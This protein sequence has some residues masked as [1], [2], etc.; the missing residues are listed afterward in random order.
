MEFSNG[1]AGRGH[2]VMVVS[3]N[4]GTPYP[5]HT[6]CEMYYFPI[7]KIKGLRQISAV[8]SGFITLISLKRRWKPDCLYI[9]RLALDPM[10]GVFAWLTRTPLITETNGQVEIHEYEVPLH[11]LWRYFWYPLLLFFERI[12]FANSFAVTADG[13][14]R[15]TVFHRRYPRWP[16]RF[17]KI[18]SGG[19]DLSKF[20]RIDRIEARKQLGLPQNRRILIW[21]GTVFAWSGLQTLIEAAER[22]CIAYPE[23]FFLIIG[24]GPEL[25]HF[26]QLAKEKGLSK[27]MR[28]T[29]YIPTA[30]LFIWLSASDLALAPYTRLRLDREDFTS[31]KIFEYLACGLPVVCS[32]EKGRSNIRYVYEYDLGTTVPPEDV[33]SFSEAVLRVLGETSF[34]H[35]DFTERAR[36]TLIELNLTWDA[37]VDQVEALCKTASA[38][39]KK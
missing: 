8:L 13:E 3:P 6:P 30:E 28:F 20:N 22:I 10:P 26:M 23:A 21:V 31:Y 2:R 14:Q 35:D 18:L 4:K 27:A 17:H 16:N 9:R 34:F 29:G 24:D 11:V 32:Y 39:S 12:L 1:L 25:K 19:I 38:S 37:L 36:S 5:H 15:L 7:I 33:E